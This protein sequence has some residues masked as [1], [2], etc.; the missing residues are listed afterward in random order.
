MYRKASAL[1]VGAFAA[2]ALSACALVD[3]TPDNGEE[4]QGTPVAAASASTPAGPALKAVDTALGKIVTDTKGWSLYRWDKD[5]AKP[6]KSNCYDQCAKTWP[7]VPYSPDF[8]LDGVT[9]TVVGK[10]E[11]TDGVTQLTIN[12][13]PV[14]RYAQDT[15]PGDIKGQGVGAAWFAVTPEGKKAGAAAS[16]S[17]S[18]TQDSTY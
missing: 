4:D 2:F 18:P 1:I 16:S 8:T 3:L 12:G 6:A 15:K 10:V 5:T 13:W 14:Y 11:R 9:K 17:P 7:P